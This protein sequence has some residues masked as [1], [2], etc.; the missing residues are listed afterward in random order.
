MKTLSNL[1]IA[2]QLVCGQDGTQVLWFL[3]PQEIT[4]NRE[5][6]AGV[7]EWEEACQIDSQGC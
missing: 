1:L 5:A 4:K 6:D 3:T 7:T 2:P